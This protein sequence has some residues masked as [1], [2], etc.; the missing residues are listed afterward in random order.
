MFL[1]EKFKHSFLFY[2]SIFIPPFLPLHCR[3][4]RRVGYFQVIN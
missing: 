4:I 2:N 1:V 3:C